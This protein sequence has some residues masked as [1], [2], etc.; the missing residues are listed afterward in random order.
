MKVPS[1][2]LGLPQTQPGLRLALGPSELSLPPAHPDAAWL[3]MWPVVVQLWPTLSLSLPQLALLGHRMGWL[4]R[5]A[6]EHTAAI[7]R[8]PLLTACCGMGLSFQR[9]ND[10]IQKGKGVSFHVLFFFKW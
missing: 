4:W 6:P 1:L 5:E 3:N 2:A 8:P 7:T 10:K 9:L